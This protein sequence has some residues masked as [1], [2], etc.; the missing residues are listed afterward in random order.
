[1]LYFRLIVDIGPLRALTVT[2]LTPVFGVAWG[3]LFLNE[4]LSPSTLIGSTV[5]LLGTA[6]VTDIRLP[7]AECRRAPR[8]I[9]LAKR[10]AT[11]IGCSLTTIA[12]RPPSHMLNWA[13]RT[14]VHQQRSAWYNCR[15]RVWKATN[16]V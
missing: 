15:Y 2:I 8:P 10:S 6:F 12:V 9:K 13:M 16:E 14:R 5:I 4:P 11:Q 3:I 1:M 7:K